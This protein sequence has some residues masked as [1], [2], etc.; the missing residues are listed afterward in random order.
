MT[1]DQFL[2]M[3]D[4][5]DTLPPDEP[6]LEEESLLPPLE[7]SP[8][9]EI[10]D[11]AALPPNAWRITSSYA[12]P[13]AAP[14]P[15]RPTLRDSLSGF[16]LAWQEIVVFIAL[17]LILAS[18]YYMRSIGRSWDDYTHLHPDERF[19]TQMAELIN[20]GLP[21]NPAQLPAG[22][23]GADPP[24]QIAYCNA[25]YPAPSTEEQLAM[26]QEELSIAL[27]NAGKG[28]YF[29]ARCSNLNPNKIAP[30]IFV[31]G[32]FPLFA[33]RVLGETYNQLTAEKFAPQSPPYTGYNGV[34]LVGRTMSAA[35]DTLAILL[36][37]LI[38][39]QLFG[40]WQGLLAALFYA[41]AAFPIQQ[42]HFWTADAFTAF[43]VL[44]GI[45]FAV[46]VMDYS[47]LIPDRFPILAWLSTALA[48]SLWD[49]DANGYEHV[50]TIAIY[51]GV[52]GIIGL[53][54]TQAIL[55][56]RVLAAWLFALAGVVL[57]EVFYILGH[58]IGADYLFPTSL[59]ATQAAAFAIIVLTAFW[60]NGWQNYAAFTGLW[61]WLGAAFSLWV[62]DSL[63]HYDK[64]PGLTPLI[65]YILLFTGT[66][67]LAS[68]LRYAQLHRRVDR[69][70]LLLLPLI[71]II[72]GIALSL[73]VVSTWGLV[74]VL[75]MALLVGISTY[76]GFHDELSFGLAFGASLAGRVNIAPLVGLFLLALII[77]SFPLFNW[78]M[79][80]FEKN[81]HYSR[82]ATGAI[83]AGFAT[84]LAFR[85]LQPHAFFGP[86]FLDVFSKDGIINFNTGWTADIAEAQRLVS[87]NADIPPNWQWTSRT[88]WLFPA[89]NIVLYGLGV[90]L[91]LAAWL[92][93]AWSLV[94]IAR[95]RSGWTRLALPAAWLLVYFGWLGRNWVTTMRYFMPIYGVLCLFAAWFLINLVQSAYQSRFWQKR[96]SL[97]R[98]AFATATALLLFVTGY[99]MVYGYGSTR[100][101]TTQL[102][103][104]AGSRYAQE[105]I[106]G[107]VGLFIEQADG[108]TR[109]ANMSIWASSFN[110]EIIRLN[111]GETRQLEIKP[112]VSAN[113][114]NLTIHLIGDPFLDPEIER[115]R[116]RVIGIDNEGEITLGAQLI[117]GD[118]SE[119]LSRY[120]SGYTVLFDPAIPIVANTPRKYYLQVEVLEGGPVMLSRRVSDPQIPLSD[121]H[122]SLGYET[123]T[124][125]TQA[126]LAGV[127]FELP[128]GSEYLAYFYGD[129]TSDYDFV[130]NATGVI[131]EIVIPHVADPI[132]DA[133]P[134]SLQIF[135][136]DNRMENS[137]LFETSGQASGDF[138][139][140][141][142]GHLAFGPSVTI[143]LD[144]P[145]PV[146][147]GRTYSLSVRPDDLL[148]IGGSTMAWEG[149]WDDP[150][151]AS[152]CPVPYGMEY[153]DDLP[154]GLCTLQTP[155]TNLY[156]GYYIGLTM[157]MFWPDEEAKRTDLLEI[158]DLTDY[159][160]IGSNRFYDSFNRDPLR[161]PMSNRYYEALFSGELGFELVETFE[162]YARFGPF[163]WRDQILPTSGLYNT[164]NEYE[165]EE[166]YHVYTHPA[167]FIFRK[168]ANYSPTQAREI[169]DVN[170]RLADSVLFGGDSEPVNRIVRGSPEASEAPT[171]LE[172]YP[173]EQAIQSNGGTWSDLFNRDAF[174]NQNELA[175][176]L[177]WWL[178]MV[179]AGWLALPFLA[180]IFPGL[181]DRGFG[182]GKLVTWLLVSWAAWFATSFRVE[183][184]N[185]SGLALVLAIFAALNLILA[186]IRRQDLLTF[187]KTRWRHLLF[188]EILAA[189]LYFV[190]IGIRLGNP[191]LWH[192]AFG[193]EKPM[194]FAY[195]NGVLRSTIFP[196]ID[197]WYSSGYI[198]YYYW[199]YVLVGAPTKLLG[200][201]PSFAYNLIL[202]TLFSMTGIGAFSVAYNLVAWTVQ[203]RQETPIEADSTPETPDNHP[204]PR[205]EKSGPV[206]NPYVAGIAAL[207]L[208]VVLGNL[209]TVRVLGTG[210]A[211]AGGWAGKAAIEQPLITQATQAFQQANGRTPTAAEYEEIYDDVGLSRLDETRHWFSALW[212]GFKNVTS[213]Q[214]PLP[215]AANR[216][217]WMP[218]RVIAEL[219]EQRGHGA[220]T[221]MPFFTFLYGDLHA[222]MMA[223]P[224]TLLVILFLTAEVL[225]AGRKLRNGLAITLALFLGGMTT[226]LLRPSNTWDWPSYTVLG[227]VGLTFAA[228][229]GQGRLRGHL[230]P[231]PLYGRLRRFLDLRYVLQLWPLLVTIPLGMVLYA[232][233]Y[234]YH[235]RDYQERLSAGQIPGYCQNLNLDT[236]EES[237]KTLCED[238]LAPSLELSGLIMWGGAAFAAAILLY[239]AGLIILGNRFDRDGLLIWL[240][241]IAF[242]GI[243]GI[244]AIWPYSQTY[245]TAYGEILPWESDKTPLWAYLDIHGIFLFII[246]TMLIWQTTRWLRQ[247][248]V[249]EIRGYGVPVLLTLLIVPAT[250]LAALYFGLG[251]YR[252][253]LITL[254]MLVWTAFLFLLPGQSA[255]ERWIYVLI[256]LALG[257]SMAVEMVILQGD[258]GR[259]NSVFKFYIQIWLL[260]SI[261]SGVSLAWLLRTVERWSSLL[262]GLWQGTVAL[263]LS[264]GLLYPI[265]ATQGRFKDRFSVDYQRDMPLTLDGMEFMNYAT[266]GDDPDGGGAIPGVWYNLAGD[267]T[268]IR[269]LQDNIQGT[270][271]II[272]GQHTEYS[273]SSRISIHT[274]LPT[275]LGWRYHQ[276]QQRN[277]DKFDRL[278]NSRVG[279]VRAFYTTPDIEIALSLIDFYKI[280]YIIVGSFERVIYEDVKEPLAGNSE[281][282]FQSGLSTGLAKFDEM[283]T[284][285]LLELVYENPVC[286]D[287][288]IFDVASCPPERITHDKIYRVLP[289]A[290][291][292]TQVF[293]VGN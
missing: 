241:S 185:Q 266:R 120:G 234:I 74:S 151:P 11:E 3:H 157:N 83:L 95:A 209:D 264:I 180:F 277:L 177:I 189:I 239:V 125:S 161:W 31:Y 92:G 21:L 61:T 68:G 281:S 57:L 122:V 53:L 79:F 197:P 228:W 58:I 141:S 207:L 41:F 67:L 231:T 80:R 172:F 154:S 192:S 158:L 111:T 123:L 49:I 256:G 97:R 200:I 205:R 84:I 176:V 255:V 91:G 126:P 147:V 34:H 183:L 194:N 254:P 181:P 282:T 288:N 127:N 42:A 211:S 221:E 235:D 32:E 112:S 291:S 272:E 153:S 124:D 13:N 217:Y 135:L 242:F 265:T 99:T 223:M 51:L 72:V 33:V 30:T 9:D 78:R 275:V 59:I 50:P 215:I 44:L 174:Y 274:G 280:Q 173:D 90:A 169:L 271:N 128:S 6:I 7:E 292:N 290:T 107:D 167:S 52:F 130:A 19:L 100:I 27:R 81:I 249:S 229:V 162:S 98:P 64:N 132:G 159:I 246:L 24:S 29:D 247:H 195:F 1:E 269:W 164:W 56:K 262:S 39:L 276:S 70:S 101:A 8:A 108:T 144:E 240:A 46:R 166:A 257:L 243:A 117:E 199:G 165:A 219:S 148:T 77:R 202:P 293:Q 289:S 190:F 140:R 146:E 253:F 286:V 278:L 103:R 145:F 210:L 186:Y 137:T 102:T 109:M 28:P 69:L 212:K 170:I 18:G 233:L 168:T 87:G 179:L 73:G 114:N 260:F 113:L 225:A 133:D 142:D 138:N 15:P 283:V 93:F 110:P 54:I 245:A 270:P 55:Q 143:S 252:I 250:I 4:Q 232:G 37:F 129:T 163:E 193:G 152:V 121:Y 213:G 236:I 160:F 285:G 2:P 216:W 203:R 43:W 206:A 104:V 182:V 106:P 119:G 12:D 85:V 187:I 71:F 86:S 10:I 60:T 178:T 261:A 237:T 191:D 23:E 16:R 263:L 156:S 45:Y 88:P 188:I 38:G 75:V 26:S 284:L 94:S 267:Y 196:A 65:V 82:L 273:W 204:A 238:H 115:L 258:N 251:E 220:I 227:I 244:F 268:M 259:Q 47:S 208:A 279:N 48:I 118:F 22:S 248:H 139:P 35:F 20:A 155:A 171:A 198:N 14:P 230:P 116:V 5:N 134:E 105:Y 218:T 131:R 184:W 149:P 175:G 89:Q 62:F 36:V 96:P 76:Y 224:L 136:R 226:G 150:M 287:G 66:G 17:L 222:H 214:S 25:Q 40:R 201:V 63:A